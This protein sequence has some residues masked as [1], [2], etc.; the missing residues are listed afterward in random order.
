MPDRNVELLL[1][2][3]AI[4]DLITKYAIALDTRDLERAIT[5]FA[6]GGGF[7]SVGGEIRGREALRQYYQQRLSGWG[8]TFHVPHRSLVEFQDSRSASGT[9]LAH[10]E[11]MADG[12]FYLA[13][14]HYEDTYV[15]DE[16]G[17][18]LFETREVRFIYSKPLDELASIDPTLPRRSWPGSQPI[19]ADIPESLD[20]YQEFR[21]GLSK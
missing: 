17:T 8:P 2:R 18:W 13:A 9:V 4:E 16:D 21:R 7:R 12:K 1:N 14:H 10:S 20:T 6:V 11:I 3:L 15:R 5:C 19:D